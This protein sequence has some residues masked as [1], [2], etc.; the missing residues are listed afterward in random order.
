[1]AF[2]P[3]QRRLGLLGAAGLFLVIAYVDNATPWEVGFSAF[4]L[5]TVILASLWGGLRWGLGFGLLAT[6][7][8]FGMDLLGGKPYGLP[9]Y[10]YWDLFNNLV[11]NLLTPLA[12]HW[13]QK[14]LA[15]ERAAREGLQAAL[16]E[17]QELRARLPGADPGPD[18]RG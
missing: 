17:V 1:M 7:T 2:S 8:I 9:F 4:Y 16:S 13:V 12:I 6:G 10:R 11:P 5:V 15:R 14:A 18:G 3:R